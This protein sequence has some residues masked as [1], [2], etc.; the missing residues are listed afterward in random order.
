MVKDL[1]KQRTE[2]CR[3]RTPRHVVSTTVHTNASDVCLL[4]N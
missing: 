4:A 1:L 3:L 2:I